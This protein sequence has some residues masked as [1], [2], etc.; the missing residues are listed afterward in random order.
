MTAG[1][2]GEN[3]RAPRGPPRNAQ[4][5]RAPESWR[6]VRGSPRGESP[7]ARAAAASARRAPPAPAPL[8][9]AWAVSAAPAAARKPCL[10]GP[11][12]AGALQS[13]PERGPKKP[14]RRGTPALGPPLRLPPVALLGLAKR[15][16]SVSHLG[17]LGETRLAALEC[18]ATPA[19][20]AALRHI[21]SHTVTDA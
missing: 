13:Q 9:R 19:H 1:R 16:S 6:G 3:R 2:R 12:G 18:R 14:G 4:A 21:Q 20:K 5:A 10:A 11:T 8:P 15:E 7:S 17:P